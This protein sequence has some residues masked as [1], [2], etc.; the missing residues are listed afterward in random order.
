M[1]DLIYPGEPAP[2]FE[3]VDVN[4]TVTLVIATVL[5]VFDLTAKPS[6][7]TFVAPVPV[8]IGVVTAT[9]VTSTVASATVG[10]RVTTATKQRSPALE[11][12][13]SVLRTA[14]PILAIPF[15]DVT[16]HSMHARAL[17]ERTGSR[18]SHLPQ[19]VRW[20]SVS[21]DAKPRGPP[22]PGAGVGLP[23][24]GVLRRRSH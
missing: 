11:R 24:S 1:T 18:C 12:A 21:D 8:L 15:R 9:S 17:R 10:A 2:E 22:R 13:R 20:P 3:L 7:V 5:V 19:D 14:E 6:I 4:V 23:S 16:A